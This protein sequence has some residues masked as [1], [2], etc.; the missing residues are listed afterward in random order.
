MPSWILG[1]SDADP[2]TMAEAYATF[3]ARGLHCDPRPVTE[4][5][6]S[7]GSVAQ[8]LRQHSASR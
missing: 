4:V 8:G 5:L 7:T 3:A 1:V 2:L 6:D